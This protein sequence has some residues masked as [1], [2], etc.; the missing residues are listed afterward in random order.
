MDVYVYEL[1][2]A[3]RPQILVSLEG[4]PNE[5]NAWNECRFDYELEAPY[6]AMVAI[7]G[8][9]EASISS[10]GVCPGSY[11]VDPDSGIY[12]PLAGDSGD[13]NL[14]IRLDA[15]HFNP[16]T[17]Y[18]EPDVSYNVY[19]V[20]EN[21]SEATLLKSGLRTETTF[22]DDAWTSIDEGW[23]KYAVEAVYPDG[24]KAEGYCTGALE[25]R[26]V[27]GVRDLPMPPLV[28]LWR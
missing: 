22:R 28:S 11:I 19:R 20:S 10:D 1:N 16:E 15:S 17:G 25:N 24:F 3:G 2:E 4:V 23:Y 9:A 6:G 12:A 7:A 13:V 5:E 14:T 27:R 21:T 18:E 26:H 8:V